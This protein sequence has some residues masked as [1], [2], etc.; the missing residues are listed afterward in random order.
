MAVGLIL[1]AIM[2]HAAK[3][4]CNSLADQLDDIADEL[5]NDEEDE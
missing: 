1:A 2:L 3:A 4:A 5:D